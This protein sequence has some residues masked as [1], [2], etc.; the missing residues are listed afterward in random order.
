MYFLI[1][2]DDLLEKYN[3]IWD[4]VNTDIKRECHNNPVQNKEFLKTKIKSRGDE[5]TNFYN[6]K[7]PIVDFNH[8]YLAAINLDFALKNENF[9]L[10]V[11]LKK[12]KNIEKKLIRDINEY[13]I[14]FSSSEESC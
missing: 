11:F 3:T 7:I 12:C 4:K 10:Q 1:D 13:L 14:D 8:T 2:D 9:Y 5:A 6:K